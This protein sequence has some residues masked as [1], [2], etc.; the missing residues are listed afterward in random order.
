MTSSFSLTF[1][2]LSSSSHHPIDRLHITTLYL[3]TTARLSG[4]FSLV[5]VMQVPS[6]NGNLRSFESTHLNSHQLPL[7]Y[8]RRQDEALCKASSSMLMP[9]PLPNTTTKIQGQHYSSWARKVRSL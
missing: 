8:E 9:L 5:N 4:G 2:L 6:Y 7:S 3:R 1:R